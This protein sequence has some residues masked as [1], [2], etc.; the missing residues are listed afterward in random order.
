[1]S[2]RHTMLSLLSASAVALSLSACS[3]FDR[4]ENIGEAPKPSPIIDATQQANYQPVSLP[5]P[6]AV[7]GSATQEANSLWRTGNKAFF[8]DQRAT[9]VG[10]ILTVNIVIA[11]S[12]KLNN[13]TTRERAG[14]DNIG[15]NSLFGIEQSAGVLRQLP[16]AFDP[17]KAANISGTSSS[18]GK[19]TIDRKEEV[20]L[21]LAAVVTQRLP[22]G[23]LAIMGSQ[24]M[25][26]NFE[27]RVLT[28]KGVIRP[29]DIEPGNVISY[30][31]IA[32]ARI[33][34]GGRGQQTD[35][36]QPRYGQQLLDIVSPF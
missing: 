36:Q 20:K 8:R 13:A 35:V 31:K 6:T 10:D 11:D 3:A 18:D 9:N 17:S 33:T 30:D 14:S 7:P 19:G 2:N 23:N 5:Q 29:E 15:I 25:G 34:Y 32:E 16:Q 26:V 1:M 4:L 27:M 24:E 22:N 12:A 21:K 28:L